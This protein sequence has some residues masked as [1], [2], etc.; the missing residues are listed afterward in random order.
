MHLVAVSAW[1][2]VSCTAVT[3]KDVHSVIAA[4]KTRCTVD[5]VDGSSTGFN[6]TPLRHGGHYRQFGR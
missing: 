1:S 6:S 2:V 3:S 5:P 4:I